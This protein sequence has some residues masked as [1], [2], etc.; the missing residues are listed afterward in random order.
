MH[1]TLHGA[2]GIPMK[3]VY[4]APG[5]FSR[6]KLLPMFSIFIEGNR[7]EMVEQIR[8]TIGREKNLVVSKFPQGTSG[9]ATADAALMA[10]K[11][12]K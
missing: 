1:Q 3:A 12:S 8:L 5:G 9:L 10:T 6:F 4:K 2:F 7:A 11:P